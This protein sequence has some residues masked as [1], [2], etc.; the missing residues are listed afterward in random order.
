M[1]TRRNALTLG[2]RSS[3]ARDRVRDRGWG[4][5]WDRD[6]EQG[7]GSAREFGA[8]ETDPECYVE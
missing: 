6:I 1:P 4:K 7:R 8:A 2:G 3:R 5:D